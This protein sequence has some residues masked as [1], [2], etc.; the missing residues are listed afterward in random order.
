MSSPKILSEQVANRLGR[1]NDHVL[2]MDIV[3]SVLSIYAELVRQDYTKNGKLLI[4]AVQ[5]LNCIEL[6]RV[7]KYECCG[8]DGCVAVR[9]KTV[10][11]KLISTKSPTPFEYVGSIDLGNPFTH[12]SDGRL[13]FLNNNR[14]PSKQDKL[15]ILY[16]FRNNRIYIL[17]NPA[18]EV[19]SVKGAFA[20]PDNIDNCCESCEGSCYDKNGQFTIPIHIAPAVRRLLYQEYGVTREE[21]KAQYE[22]GLKK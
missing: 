1:I 3:Q 2:K 19:I 13:G 20:D 16:A 9:S 8:P 10:I 12:V 5:T 14:F 17:N 22:I 15:N 18:L 7:D 4:D 21:D 6:E 11:P